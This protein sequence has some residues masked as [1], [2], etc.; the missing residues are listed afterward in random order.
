M[1]KL[2]AGRLQRM[3]ERNGS[4]IALKNVVVTTIRDLLNAGVRVSAYFVK[5]TWVNA[6]TQSQSIHRDLRSAT[7]QK[8]LRG[9]DKELTV[10]LELAEIFG[11]KGKMD[12]DSEVERTI[13]RSRFVLRR[14]RSVELSSLA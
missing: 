2:L 3:I 10:F 11:E 6:I 13:S 1:R 8:N 4:A 9:R 7:E 14:S 12:E 5:E